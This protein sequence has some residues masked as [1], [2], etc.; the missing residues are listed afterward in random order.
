MKNG[1]FY[2]KLTKMVGVVLY[3]QA[4]SQSDCRKAGPYQLLYNKYFYLRHLVDQ[5]KICVLYHLGIFGT[6]KKMLTKFSL[7]KYYFK[8]S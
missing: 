8:M 1:R 2:A 4:V 5:L 7:S 6:V 3:G